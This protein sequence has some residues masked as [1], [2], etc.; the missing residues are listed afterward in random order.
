MITEKNIISFVINLD[1]Y[2]NNYE[3]QIPY[4]NKIKLQPQRFSAVNALNNEH[5]NYKNII[6]KV[7]LT[8]SPKSVIGCSLSHIILCKHILNN[9][10]IFD[11]LYY[12]ILEDDVFPI[13]KYQDD[14][15]LFYKELTSEIN[16]VKTI[17]NNWEII[18]LH[19][20]GPIDT[21]NTYSAHLFT[22]ST[23]AY[24]IS[25]NG[26]KKMANEKV[27]S[28]IDFITQN[29][30]KYRKYRCKK[31]L[32]YT[33]EKTSINRIDNKSLSLLLKS[34]LLK[35]I[36]PLRGE[37]LWEDYLNFKTLRL[38]LINKEYTANNLIDI[39]I[40][41]CIFYIFKKNINYVNIIKYL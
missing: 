20:D 38:P 22:G 18:Q 15:N 12:L 26:L 1:I 24:L 6:N 41:F 8:F 33:N 10:N 36:I 25:Y 19:S 13:Q 37:K 9:Y 17:D 27:T 21:K 40:L 3:K 31:N 11:N 34:N 39:T 23:A 16:N 14:V 29:F 5:I 30:L 4:L 35:T 2:K 28:H 32:F 7:S